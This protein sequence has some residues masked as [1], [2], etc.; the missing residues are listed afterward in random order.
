MQRRYFLST[1][2][3]NCAKIKLD[4]F[5]KALKLQQRFLHGFISIF[6]VSEPLFDDL[7]IQFP[8]KSASKRQYNNFIT[9]SRE[10][11]T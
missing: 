6:C 10:N 3:W 9:T 2:H 5:F 11:Y 4:F 1:A 7:L 8:N